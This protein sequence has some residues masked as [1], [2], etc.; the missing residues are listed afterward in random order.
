VIDFILRT[1][2]HVS[3][4]QRYLQKSG[5]GA[6]C[7]P[8]LCTPTQILQRSESYST[9][10]SIAEFYQPL[11]A[12]M[13]N[14]EFIILRILCRPPDRQLALDA[15]GTKDKG[16]ARVIRQL[17]RAIPMITG[18]LRTGTFE[19]QT[20]TLDHARS[21]SPQRRRAQPSKLPRNGATDQRMSK[22]RFTSVT[23]IHARLS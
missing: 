13:G 23:S 9:I 19:S 18:A 22:S 4:S 8:R 6:A 17:T 11:A 21:S 3:T 12:S 2:S 1:V 14:W 20:D 5:A 15:S 7:F 16:S 10:W